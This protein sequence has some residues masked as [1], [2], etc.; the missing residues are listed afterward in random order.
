MELVAK[1]EKNCPEG[2][3]HDFQCVE[4]L[5]Y[6]LIPLCAIITSNMLLAQGSH[7]SARRSKELHEQGTYA[8][9]TLDWGL[10][11]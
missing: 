5:R 9:E 10:L 2:I 7:K 8:P 4:L 3:A 1:K 6:R 11:F